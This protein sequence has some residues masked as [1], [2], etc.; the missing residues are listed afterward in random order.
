VHMPA[1]AAGQVT[2][3]SVSKQARNT[4]CR[5]RSMQEDQP[6]VFV[7]IDADC[8]VHPGALDRLGPSAFSSGR[9]VQANY[10]LELSGQ[11]RP[12]QPLAALA[13]KIRNLVRPSGLDRLGLPCFLNG[14]GMAFPAA[15]IEGSVLA[16][17]KITE[18]RWLTVDLALAG[19]APLLC[20]EAKVT[21]RLPG[22]KRAEVSQS[23]RWLHGHL[24][25]MRAQGPRLLVGAIRQ[26]RLDLFALLLDLIV[27]PLSLLMMLWLATL[28]VTVAADCSASGGYQ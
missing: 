26:R 6:E 27:P 2:S 11:Q 17:G 1:I 16:N 22:Q 21:S 18:D 12:L 14:S 23:T 24:E 13:F 10:L 19:Y 5:A 15:I 9:P 3:P 28:S 8:T 25:C 7:V 20:R 4:S